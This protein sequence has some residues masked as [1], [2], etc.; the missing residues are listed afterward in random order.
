MLGG[1]VPAGSQRSLTAVPVRLPCL[2]R[3]AGLAPRL[4]HSRTHSGRARPR[5][6]ALPW[7]RRGTR[8]LRPGWRHHLREAGHAV[9]A[10]QLLQCGAGGSGG[11]SARRPLVSPPAP[12]PLLSSAPPSHS[13]HSSLEISCLPLQ[14]R[15]RDLLAGA[16][17]G[18][19]RH[20]PSAQVRMP[21]S[22][23][24]CML[25]C[26][27]CSGS[28]AVPG[29]ADTRDRTPARVRL[30]QVGHPQGAG[31][32]PAG[33]GAG[34]VRRRC[35]GSPPPATTAARLGQPP[36][37][38]CHRDAIQCFKTTLPH[39]FVTAINRHLLGALYAFWASCSAFA[40]IPI[41]CSPCSSTRTLQAILAPKPFLARLFPCA[42]PPTQ[43][44]PWHCEC[45]LQAAV[46]TAPARGSRT[47]KQG[48]AAVAG[49]MGGCAAG[50]AERRAV[51]KGVNTGRAVG[52]G[53]PQRG[54]R[55]HLP[56][57]A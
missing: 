28:L 30:P 6:P 38:V 29:C 34:A 57:S 52:R 13:I 7:R 18:L 49:S 48:R 16:A 21:D 26:L 3:Q 5:A 1:A 12:A 4:A 45:W 43:P 11:G 2:R 51:R 47:R 36:T 23:Q 44:L 10:G 42:C 40:S 32:A 37:A 56:P 24:R 20:P 31:A 8:H 50:A 17:G 15:V 35:R 25:P 55:D 41:S 9:G 33:A 14:R 22:R 39:P 46:A 54:G 53:A 27:P 19:G